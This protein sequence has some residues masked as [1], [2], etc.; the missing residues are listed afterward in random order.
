MYGPHVDVLRLYKRQGFSLGKPQWMRQGDQGNRWIQGEYTVEHTG[1]VQVRFSIPVCM[2]NLFFIVNTPLIDR[3]ITYL[4]RNVHCDTP[5]EQLTSPLLG[6]TLDL[7][8]LCF[9]QI[10]YLEYFLSPVNV[11]VSE[12]N[13]QIKKK[14]YVRLEVIQCQ[15]VLCWYM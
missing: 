6:N 4:Y 8:R 2:L 3:H 5:N 14:M 13:S 9:Q 15:L 10:I 1:N 12:E 11:L 7:C